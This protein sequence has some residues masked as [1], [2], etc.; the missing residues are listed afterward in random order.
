LLKTSEKELVDARRMMKES[1][2]D[3]IIKSNDERNYMMRNQ[4]KMGTS[5]ILK[6]GQLVQHMILQQLQ[7]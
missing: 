1:R 6:E 7:K 2:K 3:R 4:I 5:G